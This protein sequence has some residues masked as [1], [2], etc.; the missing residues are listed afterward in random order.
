MASLFLA[1]PHCV[2]CDCHGH[3]LGVVPANVQASQLSDRNSLNCKSEQPTPRFGENSL[4]HNSFSTPH[5]DQEVMCH[6]RTGNWKNIVLSIHRFR[7]RLVLL[8]LISFSTFPPY[9][10]AASDEACLMWVNHLR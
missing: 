7:D 5:A 10:H 4:W 8:R 6:Q 9:K 1:F 3:P 2:T